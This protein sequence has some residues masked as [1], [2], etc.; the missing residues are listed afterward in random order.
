MALVDGDDQ[1]HIVT[2]PGAVMAEN[3]KLIFTPTSKRGGLQV[4]SPNNL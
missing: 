1:N 3:R 2:L 4:V